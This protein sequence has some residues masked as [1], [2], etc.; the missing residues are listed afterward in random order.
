MTE[1]LLKRASASR[2]S[3]Q[4]ND[5]DYDLF[6]DGAVVGRILKVHTAPVLPIS[7]SRLNLRCSMTASSF[8][9]HGPRVGKI[10]LGDCRFGSMHSDVCYEIVRT[11]TESGGCEMTEE[12][13][14][15]VRALWAAL[16][17]VVAIYFLT[18]SYWKAVLIGVFVGIS[19]VLG[20]GTSWVLRGS[21]AIAVLA[22]VVALGLPPPDQWLQLAHEA[23]EA[24]LS[25]R[26]SR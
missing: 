4:W 6:E 3:G 14:A 2:P 13:R 25:F 11:S 19:A 15:Q 5:D 21:F 7:V 23:Q 17:S 16:I 20:Y 1:R 10:G 12:K 18:E 9:R 24:I 8:S 26:T 22:I